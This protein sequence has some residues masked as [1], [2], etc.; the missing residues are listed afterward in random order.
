MLILLVR[1]AKAE[2]RPLLGLG[3]RRDSRRPLSDAGRKRMRRAAKTLHKLVPVVDVL[4][5]SP[6]VRARETAEII[7]AR[8]DAMPIVDLA[9]LSP[10]GSERE[11][12]DWLCAQR[13]DATI[14]LVGHEPDL[15]LFAGWLL[16][17][18]KLPFAPLRK[19]AACLIR[20]A[21]MPAPGGGVLEWWLTPKL[22]DRLG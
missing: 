6:L 1:H 13:Q 16:S 21:G 12:L 11:L 7:A 14:V 18:K 5:S 4:A 9:L 3:P 22:L 20:F 8:Y 19:G 10:G 15:G 2:P 17:G